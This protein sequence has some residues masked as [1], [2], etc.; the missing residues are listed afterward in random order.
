[1]SEALKITNERPAS[2]TR[3]GFGT[4]RCP[5]CSEEAVISLDTDDCEVLRCGECSAE[6]RAEVVRDWIEDRLIENARWQRLLDWMAS[7]PVRDE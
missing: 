1:M 4:L 6:I 7:A 2:E 3:K 5:E